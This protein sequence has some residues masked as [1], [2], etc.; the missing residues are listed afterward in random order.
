MSWDNLRQL[1]RQGL[2]PS[3]PVV[4]MTDAGKPSRLLAEEG[5]MVIVHKPGEAFHVELLD[6][7][8]VWLFL[9]SCDRAQAV[10]RT[11][12]HR[13]VQ[14]SELRSWCECMARMDSQPVCCEVA[15]SWQ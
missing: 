7:L 1:R 3:L 8:R 4:V 9:R 13:G 15:K 6:G 10:I 14:P 11:M 5:C 2:K 12:N